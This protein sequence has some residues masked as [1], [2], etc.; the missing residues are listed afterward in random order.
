MATRQRAVDRGQEAGVKALARIS[1][2]LRHARRSRGL[3]LE[4]VARDAGLS[5]AELSRIERGLVG[6]V[7]LIVLCRL[8]AIV[9]L[10]LVARA[11]P[12]PRSLK[13]ARHARELEK[14]RVHLHQ[15]LAWSTEVPLPNPDD[16]R[17][18]DAM[19]RGGGWRFGVE[20]ELN[21]IDGQALLRRLHL[22]RR[23]GFVDG[24]ILLMPDTRQ[25]R[26]FRREF[27]DQ[28]VADFPIP[29]SAALRSLAAGD[30]PGG[31]SV[32]VL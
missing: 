10:D 28:L 20:C 17:A 4:A 9:G 16:Q 18:W 7:S 2:E 3:S 21:P 25:T 31:S 15:S 26:E 24:V 32:I 19:I 29:A 27:R 8:C 13:D 14:L 23:D 6:G 1:D 5:A 11:Y 22:K 12:G 30:D